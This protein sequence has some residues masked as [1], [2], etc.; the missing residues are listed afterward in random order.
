MK[1]FLTCAALLFG[2]PSFAATVHSASFDLIKNAIE[3]NVSY[4]GCKDGCQ[5]HKF[6]IRTGIC[7]ETYPVQCDSELV[8]LTQDN[9]CETIISKK[10]MIPLRET[11]L[12]EGYYSRALLR[13]KGDN[14]SR[15][16]VRLPSL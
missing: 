1:A 15:V 9:L 11:G 13:I 10:I 16:D 5:E 12:D 7:K 14:N 2:A 4:K 8:E 3:I 6:E